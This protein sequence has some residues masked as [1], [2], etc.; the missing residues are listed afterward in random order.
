MHEATG[1][2]DS[3]AVRL[4]DRLVTE[5]HAKDGQDG[6]QLAH[7]L[8]RDPRLVGRARAGGDEHAI[9][10]ARSNAGHIDGVV[11][12]DVDACAELSKVLDE[13]EGERIIVVDD[14]DARPR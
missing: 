9:G 12:H 1:S 2:H 14:E 11:L 4:T 10:R 5:A 6:A 13:V 3:P 7:N 8:K